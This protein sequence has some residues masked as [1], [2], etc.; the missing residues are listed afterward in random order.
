MSKN[1]N[2][3]LCLGKPTVIDR[4]T[5]AMGLYSTKAGRLGQVVISINTIAIYGGAV[6]TPPELMEKLKE[7]LTPERTTSFKLNG[8]K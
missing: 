4:A 2:D 7:L 5:L 6:E 8:K 1:I 3:K